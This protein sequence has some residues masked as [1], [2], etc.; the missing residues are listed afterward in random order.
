MNISSNQIAYL[1]LPFAF[2]KGLKIDGCGP[3]A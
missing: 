2:R 3:L 1:L